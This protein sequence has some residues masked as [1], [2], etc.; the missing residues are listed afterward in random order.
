MLPQSPGLGAGPCPAGLRRGTAL[1]T[2]QV[3]TFGPQC[4]PAVRVC[5]FQP[6]WRVA[7]CDEHLQETRS[8]EKRGGARCE[9][10]G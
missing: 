3:W 1:P 10:P 4:C 5:C 7:S 9:M 8:W 2:P 6:P